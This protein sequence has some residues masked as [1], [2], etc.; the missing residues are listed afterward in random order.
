MF[1]FLTYYFQFNLHYSPLKAGFAFLPFSAGII[2]AAVVVAQLLPRTGPRPLMIPGLIL[3][4]VGMLLLTRIGATTPYWSHVLPAQILMSVGLAGVFIP[5]ASTALIGV[6]HH[7]AGVA[8]AVLNSSQQIGGSL[9]TALLNTVFASTVT[10]YLAS[11]VTSP[12]QIPQA[13]PSAY[14]D[15][16]HVAF[17]WGAILLG[18]A[19]VSAA[20][21]VTA[22]KEDMPSDAAAAGVAA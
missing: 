19:L 22:R 3:A 7:D 9:G 6:G 13:L 2:V 17:L 10:A 14:I 20:V 12:A 11:N 8:S 21:F 1:L 16:Y 15:G 4:I 18:C 5:A